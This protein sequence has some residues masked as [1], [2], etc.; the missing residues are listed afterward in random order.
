MQKRERVRAALAGQPVDHVPMSFW[1]HDYLREWS[2]RGLADAMLEPFFRYDWDYMKVNPRAT[3]YAEAWGAR[4]KPSNDSTRGPELIQRPLNSAA[5]LARVVRVSGVD[6]PF[7][8]QLEALML[9]R[10]EIGG[11]DFIQ[12]VFSP[13]SV[14]GYLAGRD[15]EMVRGWM[16]S[17]REAVHH[18]LS[19][20]TETLS[21]YGRECLH[22]GASGIFFA[23]T[24]WA[25]TDNLSRELYAEFGRPYDLEVLSAVEMAEFNVLHVCRAHNMIED[26]LDYPVRAFHWADREPGNPSLVELAGRVEQAVMGGVSQQ[27]IAEGSIQEV[28]REVRE[29][30][31][32][33]GGRRVLIAPGCSISP[34]TPP[35]NLEAAARARFL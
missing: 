32:A 29:A 9:I 3:Y 15:L 33:M 28:E 34:R 24:D 13:L 27:T 6:G 26:M 2:P 31:E 7:A 30:V 11:A 18:A 10:G 14:L 25:T 5:D 16:K 19:N 17:D 4:Y 12:T 1:G 21:D 35:Q 8:E 20:L 23:T 22:A